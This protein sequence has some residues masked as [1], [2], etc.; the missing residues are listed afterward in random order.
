MTQYYFRARKELKARLKEKP[1]CVH[2]KW[3]DIPT[4]LK[5][6]FTNALIVLQMSVIAFI[7]AVLA[8][9]LSPFFYISI[10]LTVVTAVYVLVEERDAQS[11]VSW[12]ILFLISFG[13]GYIVYILSDKRVCYGIYRKKY[14][15][16]YERSKTYRGGYFLDNASAPVRRDCE[17]IYNAGG[18][19]PYTNTDVKYFSNARKL[20]DNLCARLEEA[21]EFVFLEYFIVAEGV[22]LERLIDVLSR[23]V[24]EGVEVRF[25][26]DDVGSQGV[27]TADTKRRI[28]KAGI[29]FKVFEPLFSLFYFGLNYRDHRKIIVIDGKTGYVGGCNIADE[30]TNQRRMEGL[31]KDAGLRLDGSAVDGLTITFL[32]QWEFATKQKA[33][34][35]RYMYRAERT[36]NTSNV[37]PFAGGPEIVEPL[38]RGVYYNMAD[39]AHEKLYIMT[40]YLIPDS[41][42]LNLLVSKAKSGC[43]VRVVLPA[44]P[45]YGYI[46]RV[47]K[48][49]AER[50]MAAGAKIYYMHGVFVH[51]KVM[52]TENAVTVGSVNMDMRAFY[53]EFDNGVY[54]DDKS[55]MRDVEEDFDKVFETNDIQ[56]PAKKNVLGVVVTEVLRVVSPLM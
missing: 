10:A 49:Y 44:V 12:L 51:S 15:E 29:K 28:K 33:E 11:K 16:I 25:L 27:L 55:V 39:A 40:P 17:Y 45:D 18:Y 6:L 46:Y 20:F 53:Q 8:Y 19:V 35:G 50:L 23:K 4:G 21:K 32:R 54:T 56:T 3:A 48:F 7:Y 43:D 34:F 9:L 22:L 13:A 30:C 24:A 36:L 37:I 5:G 26:Y 2:K 14:R 41:D 47:T 1:K 52:L 42:M 38:C 31:W